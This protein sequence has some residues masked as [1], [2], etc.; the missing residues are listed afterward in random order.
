MSKKYFSLL[1]SAFWPGL[2]HLYL[3]KFR[4][5][6]P[7]FFIWFLLLSVFLQIFP[8]P[9]LIGPARQFYPAIALAVLIFWAAILWEDLK[10]FK[11]EKEIKTSLWP[12]LP[13]LLLILIYGYLGLPYRWRPGRQAAAVGNLHTHSTCSDGVGSYENLIDLA[14]KLDFSFLALTDHRLLSRQPCT[15]PTFKG[16]NNNSCDE[17]LKKCEEEKRLL[18]LHGEEINL[19]NGAQILGLGMKSTVDGQ[20]PLPEVVEQIHAQ[21]GIVIA[22]HPWQKETKFTQQELVGSGFDAM[23]CGGGTRKQNAYFAKLSKD[24]H[25]PCVY[26][27]DA[28]AVG[29][30]R[31]VYNLCDQKIETFEDLKKA[32]KDDTC[33]R[34]IPLDSRLLEIVR[35][36]YWL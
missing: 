4:D 20:R 3:Q 19:P 24:Y 15:G 35:P 13:F 6:L 17:I 12:L 5:G 26:N 32:I 23:E 1:L 30:L 34:F 7:Y 10:I 14:K 25:L 8:Q 29:T 36:H 18:C 11:K 27:S 31:R 9:V 16:C 22:A 33:R 2:G 21:G 28:H